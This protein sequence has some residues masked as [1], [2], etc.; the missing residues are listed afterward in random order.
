M[1]AHQKYKLNVNM[2]NKA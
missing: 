2:A 1:Q